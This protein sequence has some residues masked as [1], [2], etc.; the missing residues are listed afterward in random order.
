MNVDLIQELVNELT[1]SLEDIETQQRALFQ[2][3]KDRGDFADEQFAPYLSQAG[4]TSGVR[5]RA[6]RV[7][8]DHLIEGEKARE[9]K[10][11]EAEKE[12][13]QGKDKPASGGE[14]TEGTAEKKEAPKGEGQKDHGKKDESKAQKD[15]GKDKAQTELDKAETKSE[16][17]GTKSKDGSKDEAGD[18]AGSKDGAETKGNANSKDEDGEED[19]RIGEQAYS[20]KA[21]QSD[22]AKDKK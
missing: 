14:K 13:N 6:V 12:R 11:A 20:A 7:R 22:S 2:F 8:L 21:T 19:R 15:D 9:E 10:A 1:S 17:D 4:K 5:W 16:K 18:E 3:L